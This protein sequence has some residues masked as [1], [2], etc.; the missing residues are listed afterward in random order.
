MS[1]KQMKLDGVLYELEKLSLQGIRDAQG[2][3]FA[4]IDF[5][6]SCKPD[7]WKHGLK[8]SLHDRGSVHIDQST[9]SALLLQKVYE[10]YA[11][12]RVM[13]MAVEARRKNT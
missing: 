11:L 10:N 12:E 5:I 13:D 2:R 7:D 3:N 6:A 1:S 4:V 9:A 8:L